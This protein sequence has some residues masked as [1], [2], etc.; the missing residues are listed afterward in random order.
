MSVRFIYSAFF[1]M[2]SSIMARSGVIY[3]VDSEQNVTFPNNLAIQGNTLK[4]GNTTLTETQLKALLNL[5]T[6]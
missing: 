4:I 5:L 1:G 2:G 6:T 3:S